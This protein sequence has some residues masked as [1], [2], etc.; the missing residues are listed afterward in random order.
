MTTEQEAREAK[1]HLEAAE[2][3][4][5]ELD[6]EDFEFKSIKRDINNYCWRLE[7]F[8]IDELARRDIEQAEWIKPI[9]AE[10]LNSIGFCFDETNNEWFNEICCVNVLMKSLCSKKHK[11]N[12]WK[13][14]VGTRGE[15]SSLDWVMSARGQLLCL[16][17]ALKGCSPPK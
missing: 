16:I 8:A 17:T 14:C 12:T 11:Q 15:E 10:W 6:E 2:N 5:S 9:D 3:R 13:C 1:K 4:L 7:C